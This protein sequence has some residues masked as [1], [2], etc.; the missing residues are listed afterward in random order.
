MFAR[1]RLGRHRV[2]VDSAVFQPTLGDTRTP[3]VRPTPMANPPSQAGAR[4]T[5][6]S[7]SAHDD[8]LS[9]YLRQ[10]AR[11]PLL[12]R[13]GEIELARRIEAAAADLQRELFA[14][15][16]AIRI[17]LAELTA[18]REHSVRQR[19]SLQAE[20]DA[21]A[22]TRAARR[23]RRLQGR[24]QAGDSDDAT[25]VALAATV[26]E[27]GPT[28]QLCEVIEAGLA[29]DEPAHARVRAARQRLAAAKNDLAAAN[30]RLV[31]S[32]AR[33]YRG[34]SLSLLDLVQEGN[35]GLMIAVEKFDHRRGYKFS[36]YATWWI[37]QSIGRAI[38][39]KDRTI[40]LPVHAHGELA[41]LRR[42]QD[43][44]YT[45]LGRAPSD[46]ELGDALGL[47]AKTVRRVQRYAEPIASL[48]A[49]IGEDFHLA[50]A[51]SDPGAIDPTEPIAAAQ[52][53][54]RANAMLGRIGA[55]E[56][57]ILRERYGL[58]DGEER[59]LQQC[60]E[61]LGITRE[62]VR[63]VA[64]QALDELRDHARTQGESRE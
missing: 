7:S 45:H 9:A 24:I 13:E 11:T 8:G 31:V 23:I 22:L 19:E 36:T 2:E 57:W 52:D 33:R 1:L 55:R 62:R 21:A 30:L 54:Q 6:V 50:D 16:T 64:N 26:A 41:R 58:R 14:S 53:R 44:L 17:V 49:P 32:I 4:S 59:T 28:A 35:L 43:R 37:R 15:A 46:D 56:A 5:S 27:L 18:A 48:E 20:L 12:T 29:A 63:Q 10:I 61:H 38:A 40:R 47:D 51:L 39:N 60:G 3:S 42:A 25:R 34:R